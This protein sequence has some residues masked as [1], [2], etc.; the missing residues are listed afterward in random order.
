MRATPVRFRLPASARAQR[1]ILVGCFQQE[2]FYE[3][4]RQRWADLARSAEH[5]LAFADF[6]GARRRPSRLTEV[7]IPG[8]SPMVREWALIC[9]APDH[10]ACVA[11]WEHAGQGRT[12]DPDRSSKWCGRSTRPWS[13]AHRGSL[14]EWLRRPAP[15]SRSGAR[16]A[17]PTRLPPARAT[18][19]GP[20]TFSSA[21]STASPEPGVSL[22]REPS[23]PSRRALRHRGAARPDDRR[24]TRAGRRHQPIGIDRLAARPAAAACIGCASRR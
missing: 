5:T 6:A 4:S 11:G 23:P 12:L 22:A 14:P 2:R 24:A 3:A 13:A 16:A 1:P 7:P 21:P 9:D 18:C 19:A 20:A 10:P 8:T 17:L 15:R